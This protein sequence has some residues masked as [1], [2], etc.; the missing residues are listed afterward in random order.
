MA[1][2]NVQEFDV[3]EDDR[4]TTNYDSVSERLAIESDPPP[5]LLFHTAGY[6]GRGQFRIVNV[7]DSQA[8]L[9]SF[10]E[11]RLAEVLKPLMESGEANAPTAAYSYELHHVVDP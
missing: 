2:M 5:G 11:G 10:E 9:D 1:I 4:S 7:W 6:T 3:E 8:S